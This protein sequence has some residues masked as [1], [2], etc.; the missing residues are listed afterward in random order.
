MAH[1]AEVDENNVVVR[2]LV[3]NN[4]DPDEGYQWLVDNLGG[5]WFKCSYNTFGNKH[6]DRETGQ[7]SA[8]Q[9]KALRGNFPGV[10]HTYD[11][12]LDAFIP[13]KELPSY[14]LNKE[15]LLWEPPIPRP[16]GINQWDEGAGNWVE[17]ARPSEA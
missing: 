1:W 9:S 14:V 5:T 13:P 16:S 10:G 2:V 17:V 4:E 6:I 8:D 11:A 3:G 7:E 15:T 12:E